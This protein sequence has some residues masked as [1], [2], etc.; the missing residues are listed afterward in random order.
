[1]RKRDRFFKQAKRVQNVHK[2]KNHPNVK[3]AW[4]KWR[5]IRN[6]LTNETRL[7]KT[8]YYSSKA[9]LLLQYKH[10][11]YKY[12]S[13]LREM[14]GRTKDTSIPPLTTTDQIVI[15]DNLDKAN[16]FNTFFASQSK[17]NMEEP[18]V[19]ETEPSRPTIPE[20]SPFEFTERDVLNELN[21]LKPHKSTGPDELPTKYLKMIALLI[22]D[23]LSKLFNKSLRTGK[24][25]SSWKLANVKPI[26]KN[27]GSPSDI[28]CYRPISLL[29]VISKVFEKLVF[30]KI[31][32]HVTD[33][34]L[35]TERQSG[36]RPGQGTQLQLFY[37]SHKL[38]DSLDKGQDFTAI[39][40]DISRYFDR[41]WHRGLIEKCK[42]E[43]GLTPLT[44]WITSY[45]TDRRQRTFVNNSISSTLPLSAGCPQGSVLGP[46]LALLYL[47]SLCK[48]TTNEILCFADDTSIY[49]QHKT[50]TISSVQ[51][52]LQKDLD[53]IYSYGKK[54]L[55]TFNATK[56][57]Q[58]TFSL[59]KGT[60]KPELK[61]GGQV[62]PLVEKH[63]HLGVTLSQDL[64][65]KEHVNQ[66]IKK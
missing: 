30:R 1:M 21:R 32:R 63:K 28:S 55:I 44:D 16:I 35:L 33:N 65:F 12:H 13:T 39:Y 22:A 66:I 14:T 49:A 40:L 60:V 19:I 7:V 3:H 59:K 20:L 38:Y 42:F 54:W 46:F 41:I 53:R 34:D 64:H 17:L 58:Q 11:P 45:L 25:P 56:T 48:Q 47:N 5:I 2:D 15:N 51:N 37:L 36:Y 6:Q 29:C 24:F 4:D 43:F 27:K 61:F 18:D 52:S 10:D 26:F 57:I 50:D 23:P 8:N 62:I 31:Y 9:A